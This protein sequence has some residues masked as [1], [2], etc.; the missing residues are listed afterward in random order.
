MKRSLLLLALAVLAVGASSMAQGDDPT[1]DD[2]GQHRVIYAIDP[3]TGEPLFAGD[4]APFY[5]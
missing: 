3:I 4:V 1:R 5:F 2:D